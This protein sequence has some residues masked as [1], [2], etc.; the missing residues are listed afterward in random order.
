[1]RKSSKN[2]TNKLAKELEKISHDFIRKRDSIN[3]YEIG[4]YC[5]DCGKLSY[6]QQFPIWTLSAKWKLWGHYFAFIH[7]ICTGNQEVVIVNINKKK[8]K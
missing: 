3:D 6:G 4:G 2:S 7:I 5:F 8:L 1:M